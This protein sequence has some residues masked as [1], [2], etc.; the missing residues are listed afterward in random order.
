MIPLDT[1][2]TDV[3][4]SEVLTNAQWL[5]ELGADGRRQ[6][7]AVARL[8]AYL[9]RA[10]LV[11]LSRQRSDLAHFDY[12]ELRQLA[13]DWAQQA[14]VQVLGH[15][16]SFRGD[17]KFTTWAYRIAINLAAGELRLKR[18]Q[19]VSLDSMSEGDTPEIELQDTDTLRPEQSLT[20]HQ[21]WDAIDQVI[22][23]D[24]TDR[25]RT[26]LQR[27]VFDGIPGEQVAAEIDTNRNN[28]YK[29]LHDARQKIKRR[30][31]ALDWSTEDILA[32]FEASGDDTETANR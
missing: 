17:S 27:V 29:I 31:A 3:N 7:Q 30:L 9:L 20:R 14:L 1:Q 25:Q 23:N 21:V 4:P 6:E 19:N 13:E 22:A 32:A 5:A 18:W 16:D 11:Y 8:R 24:L 12:D 2:T 28:L 10:I 15:L 26:V